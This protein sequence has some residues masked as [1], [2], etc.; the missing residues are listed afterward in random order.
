M[1]DRT[2]EG[3]AEDVDADGAL[4]VHTADGQHVTVE[5]GDVTLRE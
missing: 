5:A 4:I 3:I 2:V 1:P